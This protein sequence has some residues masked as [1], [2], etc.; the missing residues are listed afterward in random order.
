MQLMI[1]VVLPDQKK[2]NEK[3][4]T[5]MSVNKLLQGRQMLINVFKS[6]IFGTYSRA[7]PSAR[8][9]EFDRTLT[10]ALI[11]FITN[12]INP[13]KKNLPPKKLPQTLPILLTR[14]KSGNT[15]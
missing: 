8:D 15:S 9:D 3:D 13:R 5:L 14:V 11:N 2:G 4:L 1:L 10:L 6:I 12:K 7:S